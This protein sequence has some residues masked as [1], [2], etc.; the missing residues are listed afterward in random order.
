M[1]LIGFLKRLRDTP[2]GRLTE[3]QLLG[4]PDCPFELVFYFNFVSVGAI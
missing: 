2:P 3:A 4:V 1:W